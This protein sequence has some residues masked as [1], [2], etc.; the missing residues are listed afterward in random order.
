DPFTVSMGPGDVIELFTPGATDTDSF[1]GTLVQEANGRHV[2]L[3][4]GVG[5]GTV[6]AG[7]GPCGHFEDPVLPRGTLGNEYVVPAI[8]VPADGVVPMPYTLRIQ[9]VSNGTDLTFEPPSMYKNVTLNAGEALESQGTTDARV[10]SSTAFAVTQYLNG[11]NTAADQGGPNQLAV[12]PRSQ[13]QS[14]YIFLA[15][16]NINTSTSFASNLAI[17]APTGATVTIDGQTLRPDRFSPVGA[18]GMSVVHLPLNQNDQVHNLTADRPVG[19]V[20]YG[21]AQYTSFVYSAGQQIK[22]A[23]GAT[24]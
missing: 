24:P 17:M 21:E 3:L 22:A 16:Q 23:L 15:P 12:T 1:S 4:T 19:A 18:S 13:Y 2:Q 5:C 11:G 14:S 20:V 8:M 6:P 9:A 10:S 7:L